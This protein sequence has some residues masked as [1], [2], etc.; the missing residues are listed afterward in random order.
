MLNTIQ[1]FHAVNG[2]GIG[3]LILQRDNKGY[4]SYKRMLIFFFFFKELVNSIV[5]SFIRTHS[6]E[7]DLSEND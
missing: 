6:S 2:I 5:K 7:Q 1:C 3:N 4:L